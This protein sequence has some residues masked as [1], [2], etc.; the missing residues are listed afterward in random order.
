MVDERTKRHLINHEPDGGARNFADER[1]V[2]AAKETT[3]AI[4]AS[5]LT[6]DAHRCQLWLGG[7]IVIGLL[8]LV[9]SFHRMEY[10]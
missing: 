10:L 7:V 5:N 1:H 9:C 8:N 2:Q 4:V 6:N 3:D